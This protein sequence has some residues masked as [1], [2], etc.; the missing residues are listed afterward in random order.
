VKDVP[1]IFVLVI[2]NQH[3]LV[4]STVFN[5]A[6]ISLSALLFVFTR[7]GFNLRLFALLIFLSA[8]FVSLTL[9]TG[10]QSARTLMLELRY[11]SEAVGGEPKTPTL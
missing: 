10:R 1:I 3:R 8:V 11:A 9:F 4:R 6:L 5:F 2:V 7:I